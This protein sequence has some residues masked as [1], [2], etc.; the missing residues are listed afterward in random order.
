MS[1]RGI[2]LGAP[3]GARHGAHNLTPGAVVRRGA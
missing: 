3:H 1:V 2:T